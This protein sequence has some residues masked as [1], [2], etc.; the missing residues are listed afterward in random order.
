MV[1]RCSPVFS[2]ISLIE[3]SLSLFSMVSYIFVSV[4]GLYG[5][6]LRSIGDCALMTNL[7]KGRGRIY[8]YR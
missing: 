5:T 4:S 3:R 2:A 6:S 1:L 7:F 8:R